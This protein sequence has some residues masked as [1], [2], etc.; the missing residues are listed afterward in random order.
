MRTGFTYK[1]KHCSEYGI[2]MVTKSRPIL[3]ELRSAPMELPN[4]DG[5]MEYAAANDY[6]RAFYKNRTFTLGLYI[7]AANIYELEKRL[8]RIAVWLS[9]T[10]RLSFDDMPAVYWNA[11]VIDQIDYA[12]ECSGTKAVLSVSF[13]VKPFSTAFFDTLNGP[14]IG[15]GIR[16][17]DSVRLDS[18]K[19]MVFNVSGSGTFTVNN[20]GTAPV[21]PVYTIIPDVTDEVST[22]SMSSGGRA[23]GYT[24]FV[25]YSSMILDT[26]NY[27][28]TYKDFDLMG[29]I[30]GEFFELMPGDNIINFVGTEG[31]NFTITVSYAPKF[32]WNADFEGGESFA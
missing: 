30:F 24:S 26:E 20:I 14:R 29:G 32:I 2:T 11:A 10:G 5:S 7:R 4:A 25:K 12:P 8:S 23:I 6:G 15:A 19:A 27:T 21:R 16:L 1:N 22:W 18:G 31:V 28:C 13:D 17:D 3:P 9:G